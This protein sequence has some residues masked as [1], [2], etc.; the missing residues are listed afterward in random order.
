MITKYGYLLL[1][2]III[3]GSASTQLMAKKEV[4]THADTLR[5][6]L[7]P[8]RDWWDVLRYDITVKPDFE[9]KT[10]EGKTVITYQSKIIQDKHQLLQVHHE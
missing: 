3:S 2:S 7:N 4:F 1:F 5:G 9:K 6:S 8:N 10:I